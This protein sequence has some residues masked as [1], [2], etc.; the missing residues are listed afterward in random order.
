MQEKARH[1]HR[2][3]TLRHKKKM[4]GTSLSAPECFQVLLPRLHLL[5]GI[6]T[7]EE[8]PYYT[9]IGYVEGIIVSKAKEEYE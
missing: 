9:A 4:A 8:V 6:G 7:A 3:K 1:K 2:L 5:D